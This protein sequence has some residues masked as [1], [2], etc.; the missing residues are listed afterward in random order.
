MSHDILDWPVDDLPVERRAAVKRVLL[1]QIHGER[2]RRRRARVATSAALAGTAATAVVGSLLWSPQP[3]TAAWTAVPDPVAMTMTDPTVQR[4][5]ADLPPV[6]AGGEPGRQ[7]FTSVVAERR[8]RSRAV[9]LDGAYSQGVCVT[10]PTARDGGRTVS[11][12][13]GPDRALTL[14]G[15]GGSTDAGGF[16]YVYG[17]VSS[18]VVTVTVSTE[19]GLHVSSSVARGGYLAWWPGSDPPR[20]LIAQDDAGTTIARITPGTE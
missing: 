14:A 20:R 13:V 12:R 3:A 8:G 16:R 7:R 19:G 6:V 1:T 5:L 18:R 17:R 15:N 10:T 9:L 11:P 4:C 2:R